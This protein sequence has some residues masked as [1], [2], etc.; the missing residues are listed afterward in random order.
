MNEITTF[1]VAQSSTDMSKKIYSVIGATGK[2][3]PTNI[4]PNEV[5]LNNHFTDNSGKKFSESNVEIIEKFEQI[6]TI[7]QRRFANDN[8]TTSDIGWLAAEDTLNS[9]GIDR[10]SLDY[11]IFAQNFGELKHGNT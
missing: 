6:T 2:Y 4:I 10:E 5:F 3:I 11:I 1:K 7:N 9:S 8:L